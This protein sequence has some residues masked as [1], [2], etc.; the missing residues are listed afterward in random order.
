[1]HTPKTVFMI[2]PKNF[3]FNEQ[4]STSNVFQQKNDLANNDN[5]LAEF[6][7]MVRLLRSFKI[8]VVVFDDTVAPI[9]PDAVFPNNWI[10]T[11]DDGTVVLYPMM[12]ENRRYEVRPELME[13]LSKKYDIKRILDLS[14]QAATGK[15]LE[16]TGSIVFD[17]ANRIAYACESPRTNADLL[18]KLCRELD[19]DI[20]GFRASD[21]KGIDVYHTNVVMTLCDD[22][23]IICSE[24]IDDPIER[25]MLLN[26]ISKSRVCIEISRKQMYG[27]AANGFGVLDADHDHNLVISRTAFENLSKDQI[28]VI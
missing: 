12:A 4:T 1:M 16:G 28:A 8:N 27:F 6:D 11:H 13:Q 21:L 2:R 5:A 23:A 19:Y 3:G 15:F 18:S 25:K 7:E 20:V 17:H 9:K 26:Q 14:Y 10:S 22:Y 24:S